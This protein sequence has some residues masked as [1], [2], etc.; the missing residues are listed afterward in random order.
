LVCAAALLCSCAGGVAADRYDLVIRGATIIDGTGAAGFRGDVAIRDDRI[1]KVAQD[2]A[3]SAARKVIDASGLTLAPGFIEPHA[4]ITDIAS[5]PVPENFLRQG[6]TT[7]VNSLHSLDQPYPLGPF[8]DG[9]KV[10]PNTVWTAGHSWQRKRIIGLDNR[11]PTPA[12]LARM[13]QLTSE[14]MD[15]G[16]IGYATGL[17]YIPANFAAPDEV[18]ALAG[19]SRRPNAIYFSHLRDEGSALLAAVDEAINVGRK[20]GLPVHINHLKSTGIANQGAGGAVLA[21]I[22]AANDTGLQVSFDVYPYE[23]YSTYSTV[24]FPSWVLAGSPADYARR[25]DDPATRARLKQ[26]MAGIY[27]A[28]TLGTPD[29]VQFREIAGDARFAG[30]TL[31]DWLRAHNRP[32]T[33]DGMI[34][35]L[36]ELQRD[37]GFTGI[38]MAM[39]DRDITAFIRHPRASISSDGDLIAFGKGYPHPRSYGAFPRILG[40]YVRERQVLTLEA[41]VLKMTSRPAQD[42]H[43][44]DRGMVKPGYFADIVIFDAN[45]VTDHA[46]FADPHRYSEGIAYLLV[47]GVLVIES[48]AVTGAR[49][50]RALRR[51][52]TN[53]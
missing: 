29:S 11:P 2:L 22:D 31:R 34:D 12:E 23:A 49:P 37:G 19:A 6:I 52:A 16:A 48:G 8:L 5:Y 17:E 25:I 40:H 13:A 28:Q 21:A 35:A 14:A 42:L 15:D 24:L 50:G 46:T 44:A 45:R 20:T 39:A 38:F 7:I 18:I 43:I 32:E 51:V 41:A 10:A 36:I 26:E 30:K 1:V 27:Q 9:L 4:H 53:Q 47:N 33:A 3:T